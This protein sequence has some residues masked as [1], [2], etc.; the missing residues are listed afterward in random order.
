MCYLNKYNKTFPTKE[1]LNWH[2]EVFHNKKYEKKDNH[3]Q[4][5]IAIAHDTKIPKEHKIQK[6][7]SKKTRLADKDLKKVRCLTK[8]PCD[9]DEI[10][11]PPMNNKKEHNVKKPTTKKMK[12]KNTDITFSEK[13]IPCLSEG[14]QNINEMEIL[15]KKSKKNKVELK[16]SKSTEP[17]KCKFCVKS[18]SD[19]I[20]MKIHLKVHAIAMFGKIKP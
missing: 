15:K 11:I 12:P 2:I 13:D 4:N 9:V 19:L 18:F 6:P 1:N 7:H 10:E 16:G 20:N 14:N 17:F 8:K 5:D 3:P